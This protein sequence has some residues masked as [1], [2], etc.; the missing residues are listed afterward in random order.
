MRLLVN[1]K[2]SVIFIRFLIYIKIIDGEGVNRETIIVNEKDECCNMS[3]AAIPFDKN[4][5]AV[6]YK[7]QGVFMVLLERLWKY[8]RNEV[9]L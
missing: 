2:I 1:L 6:I 9:K 5:N 7:K 4:H 8:L 3:R